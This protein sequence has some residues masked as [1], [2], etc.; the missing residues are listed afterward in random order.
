MVTG[1]LGCG[2]LVDRAEPRWPAFTPAGTLTP[3]WRLQLP[4]GTRAGP[5]PVEVSQLPLLDD[6]GGAP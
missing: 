3:R 4:N 6:L 2:P 5:R 1:C